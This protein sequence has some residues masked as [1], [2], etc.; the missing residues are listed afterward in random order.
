MHIQ[1]SIAGLFIAFLCLD[2]HA[3]DGI[4]SQ[5][6]V[7]IAEAFI[8]KNGYTNL[9]VPDNQAVLNSE[10]IEWNSDRR[11]RLAQR[12]NTLRPKAI[13]VKDGRRDGSAGWSVAFDYTPDEASPDKC[14][15]VTMNL[16]G[17]D[18]RVEHVDGFRHYFVGFDP[19]RP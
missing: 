19:R 6:A 4:T 12:F 8:A 14:R 13:G 11:K 15:V 2:L 16:E 10:R 1:K 9:P 3:A 17:K 5:A 18:L 7:R